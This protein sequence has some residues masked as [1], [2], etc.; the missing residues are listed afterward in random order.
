MTIRTTPGP[1]GDRHSPTLWQNLL[2]IRSGALAL[3]VC[4]A[5]AACGGGGGGG[6]AAAGANGSVA[7]TVN[8]GVSIGLLK[9]IV[10]DIF[11]AAVPGASVT[12]PRSTVSTDAQGV[13]LLN[14]DP[15]GGNVNVKVSR[16]TFSDQAVAASLAPG[17]GNELVVTLVRLTSAAGG[18]LATRSGFSPLVDAGKQ[19]MTFEVELVLVD[20]NANPITNLSQASF[21]L[22]ACTPNATNQRVDCIRGA[23]DAA[24]MAYAPNVATPFSVQLIAAQPVNAYAAALLMDQSGSILQ[25]DPSGARLFS[26]KAFIGALGPDDRVLLSAFAGNPGALISPSPLA[27]YE[28]FKD[29]QSAGTLFPLLDSLSSRVGGNTPLYQ[30]LDTLRDTIVNDASLPANIAKAIVIFTDGTDTDCA[31]VTTCRNRRQL[32]IDAAN[33]NNVKLFTVGLSTGV[34]FAALGEL[35]SQT[36]GA[37]LYA[38]TA[39]QLLPLYGS[40]GKLLSLGLPTYRLQWTVQANAGAFQSGSTL[41]GRVQVASGGKTFEVPF[42]VGIP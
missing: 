29:S 12:G 4:W 40:V 3:A 18:S 15:A 5:I 35:A 8:P 21:F 39:E 7:A 6:G 25:S 20:G 9:V 38:D 2:R 31:D 11:G 36:N 28:S 13:A 27:I 17:V 23:N 16:D 30:S 14:V 37:F 10:K 34:D 32:S 42:V 33:A 19:Q 41:L 24:D 1:R 26:A 22:R